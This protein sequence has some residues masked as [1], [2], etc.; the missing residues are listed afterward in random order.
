MR[1]SFHPE[2][3]IWYFNFTSAEEGLVFQGLS[4]FPQLVVVLRKDDVFPS[5]F[6][7][8]SLQRY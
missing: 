5:T 6:N 3:Q 8:P 7:L 1:D 4:S 2:F